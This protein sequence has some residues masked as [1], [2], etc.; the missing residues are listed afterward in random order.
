MKRFVGTQSESG[1]TLIEMMIGLTVFLAIASLV[2]TVFSVIY[3]TDDDTLQDQEVFLFFE[4]TGKEIQ[5]SLNA[6]IQSG[7]LHLQQPDES[8]VTYEQYGNRIIRKVDGRGFETV[9]QN[10]SEF[11]IQIFTN[12]VEMHIQA[13]NQ[14]Y[15]H[16][17]VLVQ[18]VSKQRLVPNEK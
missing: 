6:Y 4:Q 16:K 10:S 18:P 7:K 14:L 11:N 9:L 15:N 3:S 5:G 17:V 13:H 12:L 8:V 2:P 1:Y